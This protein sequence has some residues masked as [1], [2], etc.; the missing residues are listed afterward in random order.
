MDAG[1]VAGAFGLGATLAILPGPVQFVLLTESTRG[2]WRR[3]F[4]AMMGANGTLG[5]ELIALAAGLSLLVPGQ[6]VLRVLKVVGGGFLMFLAF[7]AIRSTIRS[8]DGEVGA[9]SPGQT[10]LLRGVF[11]VLLNAPAWLFLATT[12]TALFATA[13]DR[14]GRPLSLLS[15][16]AMTLG[17]IVIDGCTVLLGG[18]VRRFELRVARW[19]TPILA[20]CLAAFGA[21]L[22]VEGIRG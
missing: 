16:A 22:V 9:R 13:V 17:V 1:F 14:G 2:G 6:G 8:T 20:A 5:V 4:L 19:L 21:V 3:G 11:A 7:D 10:P 18:G 15:A 12:A